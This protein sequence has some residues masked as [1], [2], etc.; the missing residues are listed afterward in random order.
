[1]IVGHGRKADVVFTPRQFFAL[2]AHMLNEN[3]QNF[4]LMPHQ[5]ENGKAKFAKAFRADA[6]KRM[7]WAWDT[8]TGKAKFPTSI[9]FYPTNPQRQSRWAA[10]DFDAHDD[11]TMRA[12]D[13]ALK[14]FAILI[15]QSDLFIAL[16]TSAG[17]P[18]HTGWHLFIFSRDFHP[19]ED[20]TRL[21]KQVCAQIGAEI[22]PD[23]CEIFPDE[24]RGPRS[25]GRAIRV[26][27]TWNP[28]TGDCGLFLHESLTQSFL[29][30]LPY[31]REREGIALS[32]LCE[33][34]R[35]KDASS[36]S[37]GVFR[38]E[39]ERFDCSINFQ[40]IAIPSGTDRG[41]QFT[42]AP[43]KTE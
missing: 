24:F 10:M 23:V 9:G 34:P 41:F 37:S 13:L 2:C 22:R 7:Q 20:W 12:R 1:V 39:Q 36:Q 38:G 14:A 4:F 33:L 43:D 15:R 26:P 19:C 42:H 31:G 21:L 40:R 30:S 17:D 6:H 35:E 8:I 29:P 5:D 28:K 25:I 18:Q 32:V 3:P 16:T 27:A 11:D